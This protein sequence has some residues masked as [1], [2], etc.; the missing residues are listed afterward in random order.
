MIIENREELL[1]HGNIKGRK[2]ALN[3]ID[4]ARAYFVAKMNKFLR[5]SYFEE[6]R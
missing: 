1:S 3:I 5:R 6:S 2:I 4:H